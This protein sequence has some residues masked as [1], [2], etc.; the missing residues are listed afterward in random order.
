MGK[1]CHQFYHQCYHQLYHQYYHQHYQHVEKVKR[2]WEGANEDVRSANIS[3]HRNSWIPNHQVAKED[4]LFMVI[5]F[6]SIMIYVIIA[7]IAVIIIII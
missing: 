6:T 4:F 3:T 5:I 2:S 1:Y 7:I